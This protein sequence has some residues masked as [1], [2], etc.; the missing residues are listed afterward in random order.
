[1]MDDVFINKVMDILRQWIDEKVYF[2]SLLVFI[3]NGIF[4]F[5]YYVGMGSFDSVFID[6]FLLFYK[7]IIEQ[8]FWEG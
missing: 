4:Y 6:K 7:I 2:F 5:G 3:D 8:F 1:M